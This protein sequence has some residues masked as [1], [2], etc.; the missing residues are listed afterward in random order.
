MTTEQALDR[1]LE[2]TFKD[3]SDLFTKKEKDF[4]INYSIE[5]KYSSPNQLLKDLELCVG[6]QKFYAEHPHVKTAHVALRSIVHRFNEKN[7]NGPAFNGDLIAFI[8]WWCN[9][10][11]RATGL[12]HC[13]YCGVDE[14]TVHT[15][16]EK[17]IIHSKKRSFNG[18]LQI[19]RLDPDGGYNSDNCHFA[20][21]LCNNAK[22]DM[23]SSEDFKE[24]IAPSVAAYWQYLKEK[25]S[26]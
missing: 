1:F 18:S 15:A 10:Y 25:H 21:V 8:E 17:G 24:Y 22:S 6:E 13:C 2:V 5:Q 11:D 4:L 12:R 3:K 14:H 26:L 9:E 23:I 20:C 7:K 16:F 19:E